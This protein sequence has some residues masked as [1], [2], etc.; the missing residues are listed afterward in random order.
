MQIQIK[1]PEIITAI[2][3]YVAKQGISLKDKTVSVTF[4][5]GRK[6]AGITADVV[7]S[8][9][10]IPGFETDVEEA[11]TPVKSE[12]VVGK[13]GPAPKTEAV[14]ETNKAEVQEPAPET[15]SEPQAKPE[16]EDGAKK[17]TTSL[18]N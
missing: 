13:I 10:S 2:K 5:A 1:Q 9:A 18:F 12:G 8:D 11:V 6:G 4:I 17:A 16:A 15:N 3:E 14:G 7:I